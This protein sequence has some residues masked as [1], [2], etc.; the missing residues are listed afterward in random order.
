MLAFVTAPGE[1]ADIRGGIGDRSR[2]AVRVE[3][4]E[5]VGSLAALYKCA[6]HK[7]GLKFDFS[8]L[9]QARLL[10]ELRRGEL[11]LG[12]PLVRR[13]DRDE[14]AIFTRTLLNAPFHLY[15]RESVTKADDLSGYT[16]A[17]LRSSASIDLVVKRNAKF[18][19]VDSWSQA[20][21]LAR[22]GRLD[23]AVVPEPVISNVH[24]ERF[25]DLRRIDFGSLPTSMYVSKV[26]ANS[27][28][29]VQSL[30]SAILECRLPGGPPH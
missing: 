11:D 1:T 26:I 5:L 3:N 18:M 20:L 6:L 4:G 27:S 10:L 17:V 2:T 25:A 21:E 7:T 14:Y 16:F 8:P 9:P 15:T 12:L 19:E 24:S 22:M 23:G 29:L 13:K 30:N 28:G